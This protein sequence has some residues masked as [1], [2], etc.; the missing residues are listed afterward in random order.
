MEEGGGG[1]SGGGR[2]KTRGGGGG[3]DR[4]G[5]K[6]KEEGRKEVRKVHRAGGRTEEDE[7]IKKDFVHA[8]LITVTCSCLHTEL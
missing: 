8:V 2:E 4:S 6:G 5:R 3:E 7:W 1:R